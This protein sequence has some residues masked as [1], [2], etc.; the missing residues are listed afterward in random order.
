[1]TPAGPLPADGSGKAS[2]SPVKTRTL[3]APPSATDK[4]EFGTEVDDL[5]AGREHGEAARLRGHP[6]GERAVEQARR[7]RG[8]ELEAGGALEDD[9][10]AAL[11][12]DLG[13]ASLEPQDLA[14]SHVAPGL[15]V[16]S[17]SSGSPGR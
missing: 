11:E 6:G 3:V 1:M 15:L 14:R 9:P 8:N 12:L 2:T 10:S 13:Q 7:G 4:P 5:A 17:R 16:R